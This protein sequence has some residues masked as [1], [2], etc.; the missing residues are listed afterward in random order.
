MVDLTLFLVYDFCVLFFNQREQ[1]E[2]T[3]IQARQEQEDAARIQEEQETQAALE[4]AMEMSRQLSQEQKIERLK[5]EL[6]EEPPRNASRKNTTKLKVRLGSG[7]PIMRSFYKETTIRTVRNWV[8][9]EMSE[10]G[11]HIIHFRINCNMPKVSYGEEDTQE[12]DTLESTGLHP[13]AM[14][15]VQDMDS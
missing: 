2:A 10:R 4:E 9:V 6:P 15:Y 1:Q 3:A 8:E 11:S 14:L 7:A 12:E 13:S 5:Q